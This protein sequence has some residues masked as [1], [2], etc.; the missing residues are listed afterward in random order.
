MLIIIIKEEEE[1]EDLAFHPPI[2]SGMQS[3]LSDRSCR[4]DLSTHHAT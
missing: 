2:K 3:L 1:E 4:A